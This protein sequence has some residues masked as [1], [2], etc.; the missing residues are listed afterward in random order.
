MNRWSP[1]RRIVTALAGVWFVA[2]AT[3]PIALHNCPMHSARTA[4]MAMGVDAGQAMANGWHAAHAMTASPGD[5]TPSSG[6][7]HMVC[8][9]P[10]GCAATGVVVLPD[11][12]A[13]VRLVA[14][15]RAPLLRGGTAIL[16]PHPA[17]DHPFAN[18]PPT[19]A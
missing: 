15:P 11:A 3:E 13:A 5:D 1:V 14:A 6:R 4:A 9:C 19:A 18:G 8:T 12:P 2:V 16:R 10:G 17:F 7:H